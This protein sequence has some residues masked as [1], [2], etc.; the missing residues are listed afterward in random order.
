MCETLAGIK[1]AVSAFAARFDAALVEPSQ[2]PQV[3]SDA[4]TSKGPSPP[5][6]QRAR[7]AWPAR[8]ALCANL[9][10]G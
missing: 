7:R 1:Q 10:L 4:G 9:S 6:R 5:S 8:P 2:L 3:L